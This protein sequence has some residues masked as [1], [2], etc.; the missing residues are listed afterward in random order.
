MD[1]AL[2]S[3]LISLG[4]NQWADYQDRQAK[5]TL[6]DADVQAMLDA[7]GPKLIGFQALI[8]AHKASKA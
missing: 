1:A 7:L 4:L 3:Q 8:D 6:T 2:I 5:G